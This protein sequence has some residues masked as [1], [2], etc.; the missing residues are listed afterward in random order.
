MPM[1]VPTG[2][3]FAGWHHLA[4]IL[5]RNQQAFDLIRNPTINKG[6]SFTEAERDAQGLQGLVPPVCES[7]ETQIGR[8]ALQCDACENDLAKY[9]FL[10]HLQDT[11]EAVFYGLMMSDPSKYM[12]LVYTPTVGDACEQFGHIYRQSKGLFLPLTLKGR[13]EEALR[14]WF[15]P[16]VRFIVVTDG[17]RILGLGDLGINGMGIPIGKLGLYSAAGGVPPQHTLPVVLDV[18]TENE[19][20]RDDPYYL[21]L[22][23]KRTDNDTYYEFVDEFIQATQAVYPGC[24]IQFEDFNIHH[25]EP[26]L[27]KYQDQICTFNDDIQGT[28]AVATA[29]IYTASRAKS[30]SITDQRI[31]FLGAG[32]AGCGIGHL[33]A[34]AMQSEGLDKAAA[35]SRIRMFDV[36]GLLTS[37]RKDQLEYFQQPFAVDHEPCSDFVAA[38]HEF[39]PT[40]IIGVSTAAGAFNKDVLAAMMEYNE[41]P[42]IFPYSNPTKRSECTAE[43]AYAATGGA[44]LFASGSPFP[45]LEVNGR[46]IAPSQ[47]N[48]VYIFPAIGLAVFATQARRVT[49]SMFLASAK[50]LAETLTEEELGIGLLYPSRDRIRAVAEHIASKVAEVVFDEN[51]AG[52]DRPADLDAHIHNLAYVP[53]F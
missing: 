30:E 17:S 18:G 38:I 31:L 52:I 48:N 16:D 2:W 10:A 45:E 12:P 19:E 9:I 42:L 27:E 1:L 15:A 7:L 23:Q 50:A 35:Y 51:L 24:C 6:T 28:A 47:G 44:A 49:E 29:G 8:A 3:R 26:L 11:S 5:M 46:M 25:A 41:R 43:E 33:I 20:L 14:N 40:G 37:S 32:S 13:L 21:G 34:S 4:R 53:S 39:K 22:K 36:D